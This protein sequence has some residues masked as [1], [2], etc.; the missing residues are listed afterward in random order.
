MPAP[1]RSIP[2]TPARFAAMVLVLSL[3]FIPDV[4]R[5]EEAEDSPLRAGAWA[6][7]FELDPTF[8]YGIGY[9]GSATLAVKRHSSPSRAFRFGLNIGFNE[10][11][12]DGSDLQQIYNPPSFPYPTSTE[13]NLDRHTE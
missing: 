10:D 4:A 2:T 3:G 8:Q 5:A 1:Y 12:Q 7:E 13:V 9:T 11:R 6:A